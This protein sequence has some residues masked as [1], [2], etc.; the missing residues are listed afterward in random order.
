[1]N[2]RFQFLKC[3]VDMLLCLHLYLIKCIFLMC[4]LS[5]SIR[6]LTNTHTHINTCRQKGITKHVLSFLLVTV[7]LKNNNY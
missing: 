3:T 5:H 4:L 7:H 2:H 6:S 1:M